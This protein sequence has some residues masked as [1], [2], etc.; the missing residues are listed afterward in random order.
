MDSGRFERIQSLF[1]EALELPAD[2]RRAFLAACCGGDADLVSAVTAMLDADGEGAPL[3]DEGIARLAHGLLGAD[4]PR[5]IGPYRLGRV[6]GEG[7]MGVVYLAERADLDSVAAIKILRDAWMS[8]AR[9]GR[10]AAEQRTLAQLNHPAIARLYDAGALA[11]GTPWIAM[12]FVEGVT[13]TAYCQ[14]RAASVA[15]RLRLFRA[16][17]DGVQ[18]AHRHLVVH[19]DLKPSNILVTDD[20]RVKLLDF[21]IAKQLDSLDLP[22]DQTRTGLRMMTPA[23]AAPEQLRGGQVGTH[24]DVYALGMILY[25][26][27]AG[28]LPFD[29]S[30]RTA[31]EAERLIVEQEPL[32]PSAAAHQPHGPAD[33]RAAGVSVSAAAWADLDVLCL[34]ALQ[35]E[36]ARRYQTVEALVRDVDHYLEGEPLEAR[37]DSVG[38]RTGKFIRRHRRG[39]ATAAAVLTVLVGLVA[40]YTSRLASARNTAQTAAARAQRIQGL[41]LSLFTGGDDPAGPSEDLRVVTVLDRGVMEASLLESEPAVQADLY[42]TLGGLYEKL[43]SLD[44]ADR[45]LHLALERRQA[46][47]GPD[48]PEAAE[49]FIALGLLRLDQAR[50]DEAE[51]LVRDGLAMTERHLPRDAPELAKAM[52][53]LG[54]VLEE[55]GS[56]AE[57]IATFE[58]AIALQSVDRRP[59]DLAA[60]LRGLAGAHFYAGEYD[61]A[62]AIARRALA[63]TREVNGDRHPLAGG[64]LITLGAIQHERGRYE[65]AER[66]YR[67]ALPIREAW[68]GQ[69]HYETASN[70]TMLG[71]S[72]LFQKRFDEAVGLLE[73]ALAIQEKVFGPVHPRVASAVNELG[74]IALQREQFDEA[75]AAFRRMADIYRSVYGT[76][77]Y[78]IGIAVSNLAS[79]Y[80]AKGEPVRAETL[81]REAIALYTETLSL[82]HLNTGIARVKLGRALVRQRRYREAEVEL[83]AG[84]EILT[85]QTSPSVSWLRAAREDLVTLYDAAG[86]PEKAAPFRS[87]PAEANLASASR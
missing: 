73:R 5:A 69:E 31:T 19:R 68:Y 72:L 63:I 54:Q 40:F 65:E 49:S 75:E 25:E 18:H 56:Y 7:G 84:H 27:L 47:F 26:L 20:G 82:D 61:E 14:A 62:D 78:L 41:M 46:L 32:K 59:A 34:T 21:G 55:R 15:E 77:H 38:Y 51:Q 29:F 6:L 71:R 28:R 9:R 53:A 1:H 16:V 70:L 85:K 17:C 60:S 4:T 36:P 2:E 74:N 8:P 66:F 42:H 83:L 37:P 43:G 10:F 22:V 58:Q 3:I 87:Q 12:E 30:N 79:V 64:D 48:S 45:L 33:A 35:K 52:T 80:L 23:Y 39:L 81:F 86:Q 13:L 67:E 44:Q 11:D 76:K 57:A 50:F 24:T